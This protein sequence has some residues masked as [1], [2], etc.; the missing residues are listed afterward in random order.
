VSVPEQ[1]WKR[2]VEALLGVAASM[3]LLAMMLLTT[4]DVVARYLFNRPLRGAFEITE[5]MLV[6]L[7]FAGLPLAKVFGGPVRDVLLDL[8]AQRD[9]LGSREWTRAND[10]GIMDRAN[11]RGDEHC[12]RNLYEPRSGR[13]RWASGADRHS[14]ERF[15]HRARTRRS[16]AVHPYRRRCGDF[17][18]ARGTRARSA[19]LY[20]HGTRDRRLAAREEAL[21]ARN[22]HPRDLRGG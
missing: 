6:V 22:E 2:H 15:G 10:V 11:S 7:I 16:C 14:I 3:I 8:R 1:A 13:R 12:S 17:L 18:A 4:V 21:S 20:S 19:R 9:D 5:L